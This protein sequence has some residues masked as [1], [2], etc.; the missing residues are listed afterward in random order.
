M[1]AAP[2]LPLPWLS[3]WN[4]KK[5]GISPLRLPSR[6]VVCTDHEI[7]PF[8]LSLKTKTSRCLFAF[9]SSPASSWFLPFCQVFKEMWRSPGKTAPKII[10]EQDLGLVSDT[11]QLHNICQK[12]VDSH[13]DEVRAH[14]QVFNQQ[15]Q[16]VLFLCLFVCW[17]I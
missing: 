6:S 14:M 4:C 2:S 5:Q 1:I 17:Q 10:Q 16:F 9:C 8:C 15:I 11:A 7:I 3:C 13:P 12:V